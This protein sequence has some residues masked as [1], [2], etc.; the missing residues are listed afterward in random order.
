[1]STE[2]YVDFVGSLRVGNDTESGGTTGQAIGS[3]GLLELFDG[4]A[5]HGEPYTGVEKTDVG[6]IRKYEKDLV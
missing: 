5:T 4:V 6:N 3:E 1:M 2:Q